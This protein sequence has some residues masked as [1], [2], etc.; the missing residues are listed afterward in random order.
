[1]NKKKSAGKKD[2]KKKPAPLTAFFALK[3]HGDYNQAVSTDIDNT[4]MMDGN[5]ATRRSPG[6]IKHSKLPVRPEKDAGI[7]VKSHATVRKKSKATPA[8]ASL[9]DVFDMPLPESKSSSEGSYALPDLIPKPDTGPRVLFSDT[10]HEP[11]IYISS[12]NYLQ[13]HF[14]LVFSSNKETWLLATTDTI[15]GHING[16]LL[17]RINAGYREIEAPGELLNEAVKGSLD[18]NEFERDYYE[19]LGRQYTHKPHIFKEIVD[20][21]LSGDG[22]VILVCHLLPGRQCACHVLAGFLDDM[23]SYELGK[24]LIIKKLE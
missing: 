12:Y 24:K 23:S 9:L 14:D 7:A 15:P 18:W 16:E 11:V 13:E 19:A 10:D 1:M 6:L 5:Q 20:L 8:S 21:P 17:A 2:K 22:R 3:S 4:F